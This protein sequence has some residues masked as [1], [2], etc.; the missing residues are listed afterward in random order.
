MSDAL[1]LNS[2]LSLDLQSSKK[3]AINEAKEKLGLFKLNAF[4][5]ILKSANIEYD[6]SIDDSVKLLEHL[7]KTLSKNDYIKI[8]KAYKELT[9]ELDK[10]MKDL[11]NGS[12][13]AFSN[14]MRNILPKIAE[15]LLNGTTNAFA[16]SA[17]IN[18]APTLESKLLVGLVTGG[19]TTF[20]LVK[21]SRHKAMV[22]KETELNKILQDFEVTKDDKGNIIDTRFK[23]DIVSTIKLFLN[24]NEIKYND[25]GYLSL[26]NALYNLEYNKKLEIANI[27]KNKLGKSIDIEKVVN[28]KGES[29]VTKIKNGLLK[30]VIVG[31]TSGIGAATAI[32]SINPA[33]AAA[34][35]NT[36]LSWLSTNFLEKLAVN[37]PGVLGTILNKIIGY[38]PV[39]AGGGTVALS[40][41]KTGASIFSIE[42][43]VVFAAAGGT[44]ALLGVGIKKIVDKVKIIRGNVAY[45]KEQKKINKLDEEKYYED[46]IKELKLINEIITKEKS[47]LVA[48]TI[49]NI[50]RLYAKELGIVLSDNINNAID[51]RKEIEKLDS[52]DKK[53]ILSLLDE[54]VEYNNKEPLSFLDYV[55]NIGLVILNAA[56]VGLASLSVIDLLT[57]SGLISKIRN[58][59]ILANVPG[60]R[61]EIL[62]NIA[63]EESKQLQNRVEDLKQNNVV[64][65]NPFIP[66][67][68]VQNPPSSVINTPSPSATPM[69][70]PT[71]PTTSLNNGVIPRPEEV[72]ELIEAQNAA[73]AIEAASKTIHGSFTN[74]LEVSSLSSFVDNRNYDYII[75]VFNSLEAASRNGK[76]YFDNFFNWLYEYNPDKFLDFI[77]YFIN[78]D[79]EI[80]TENYGL[81][82]QSIVSKI[83]QLNN[84]I[85]KH[86][87]MVNTVRNVSTKY[88]LGAG[89]LATGV[90]KSR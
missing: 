21:N 47:S 38:L 72:S 41:L 69:P 68:Q 10:V 77:R 53:K 35:I 32:N 8:E 13:D 20:N 58:S 49:V 62:P 36:F 85:N 34:P 4:K 19:V 6:N 79:F 90:T 7:K 84:E 27:I 9:E 39:I 54:L 48:I 52:K 63:T 1:V 51:L 16:F 40:F 5:D 75:E 31:G 28:K 57:G 37:A 59:S 24:N 74:H 46:N 17:L 65:S 29:I 76:L 25:T 11:I 30:P 83:Q 55:K 3:K 78:K 61:L 45:N 71:G 44:L 67:T 42:N 43:M 66:A 86:N 2:P 33:I 64:G 89:V 12:I 87:A 88:A 18:M 22:N 73:R 26:R 56:K 50:V 80:T 14:F 23:E 82:A 81:V 70:A 15:P 60:K